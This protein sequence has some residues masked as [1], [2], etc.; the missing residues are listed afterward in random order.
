M[1]QNLVVDLQ[2]QTIVEQNEEFI[3]IN[4]LGQGIVTIDMCNRQVC[5][6]LLA[7]EQ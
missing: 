4:V 7:V 5:N 3:K 6:V 2:I 1:I